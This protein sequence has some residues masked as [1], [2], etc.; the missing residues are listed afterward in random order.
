MD[1]T[2]NLNISEACAHVVQSL[3][4]GLK[5]DGKKITFVVFVATKKEEK[6]KYHTAEESHV[7]TKEPILVVERKE[8]T[9]WKPGTATTG[10]SN[11][12][13]KP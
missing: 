6:D 4:S 11:S 13:Q 7:I 5:K 9:G 2:L 1:K 8:N 12:S 3:S 10:G